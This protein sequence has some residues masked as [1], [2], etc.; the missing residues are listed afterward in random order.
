MARWRRID[1][2]I[3]REE[4]EADEIHGETSNVKPISK[5]K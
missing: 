3:G 1:A 4:K 5:D 2:L